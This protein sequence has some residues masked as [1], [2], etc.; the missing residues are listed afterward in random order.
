M[1][2]CPNCRAMNAAMIE[3]RAIALAAEAERDRYEAAIQRHWRDC[4]LPD[5][6]VQLWSIL[7]DEYRRKC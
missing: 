3:D 5:A 2:E 4:D 6:D 1:D 7:S